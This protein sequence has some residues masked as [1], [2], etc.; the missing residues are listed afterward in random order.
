MVTNPLDVRA[1]KLDNQA[2]SAQSA[3][4]VSIVGTRGVLSVLKNPP[5]PPPQA[6]KGPLECTKRSTRMYEKV[7]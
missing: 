2:R 4:N 6:K 3:M 7:H 5:P 1:R